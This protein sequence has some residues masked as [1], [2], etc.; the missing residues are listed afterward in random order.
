MRMLLV[1]ALVVSLASPALADGRHD[2]D[3]EIGSWT[4]APGGYGHVV[5][6]L[7]SGATIAQLIVPGP[8]RRVRGSLLSL[9]DPNRRL[10]HVYWADAKDGSL[11]KPLTGSFRNGVGTFTGADTRDGHPILVRIVYDRITASSFQTIQSESGDNGRR[12]SDIVKRSYARVT[13]H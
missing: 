11:S 2:F 8:A 13:S 12:W 9:Y 3:F 1:A 7:W 5:R 4:I 10:W 6:E